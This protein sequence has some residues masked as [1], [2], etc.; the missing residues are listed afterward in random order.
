MNIRHFKWAGLAAGLAVVLGV[1]SAQDAQRASSYAPVDIHETFLSIMTRMTAAKAEIMRRQLALLDQRYDLSNRPTQGATMSK[2]KP[3]QEGVRI[4]LPGG[5]TW[6]Q[7]A[8]LAPEQIK[9]RDLF[10]AGFQPLP[11][12]NHA[13]GG[14]LFP[15]FEI[16]EIKKEE[17]RDLTR[18]D[19][20]FYIPDHFLPE[21]PAPIDYPPGSGRC[22]AGQ[23]G[24][25]RE[26]LRAV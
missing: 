21:F 20:D 9:E 8:K 6:D 25:H 19:L 23:T 12:P 7:L 4:K 14:M 10:P 13:E 16:D 3:L 24:D 11:H 2:G 15:K 17:A 26:L 1:L 18:F 22:V 5:A